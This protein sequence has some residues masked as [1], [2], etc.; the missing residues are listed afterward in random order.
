MKENSMTKSGLV[1]L[2]G[3]FSL[4]NKVLTGLLAV[5]ATFVVV[6]VFG[7]N[8]LGENVA[9]I[10]MALATAYISLAAGVLLASIM[11]MWRVVQNSEGDVDSVANEGRSDASQ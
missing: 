9:P 2:R 5:P 3:K 7:Q 11:P 1:S 8:L 6:A 4:C 10:A